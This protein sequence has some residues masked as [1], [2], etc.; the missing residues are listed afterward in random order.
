[1]SIKQTVAGFVTTRR[2]AAAL[3]AALVGVGVL[4][5]GASAHSKPIRFDPAPGAILTSAPTEVNGWFSDDIRLDPNWSYLHVTDSQGNRVDTGDTK[6]STDR[7][8]ETVAAE[9][10]PWRRHVHGRVAHLR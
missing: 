6:L 7:R 3:A 1:M 9:E 8:Q 5:V 10:R 2:V 4:V